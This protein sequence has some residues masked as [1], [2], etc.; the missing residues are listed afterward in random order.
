MPD[1]VHLP[2]GISRE[3]YSTDVIF[4]T[5]Q[6]VTTSSNAAIETFALSDPAAANCSCSCAEMKEVS[7][8]SDQITNVAETA[9]GRPDMT[10]LK[11][12]KLTCIFQ[13]AE[14]YAACK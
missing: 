5:Q 9:D 7:S 2:K 4:C 11:L 13:C 14:E 6:A 10:A 1:C 8:L 12:E 3:G